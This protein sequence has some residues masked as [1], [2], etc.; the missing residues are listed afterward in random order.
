MD[1]AERDENLQAGIERA[2]S[3]RSP[4]H[5]SASTRDLYAGWHAA[6]KKVHAATT[7]EATF[8]ASLSRELCAMVLRERGEKVRA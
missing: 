2:H 1:N 3:F 6:N 7:P 4:G 5:W 8:Q